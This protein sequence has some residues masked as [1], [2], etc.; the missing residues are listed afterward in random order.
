MQSAV[1]RIRDHFAEA[2]VFE[3]GTR[4]VLVDLLDPIGIDR[5]RPFDIVKKRV[6]EN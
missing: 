3:R 1:F 4:P 2:G 6:H 5:D